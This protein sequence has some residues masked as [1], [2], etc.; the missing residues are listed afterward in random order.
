MIVQPFCSGRR[1][2]DKAFR[3]YRAWAGYF[4]TACDW[5][6]RQNG[7][8]KHPGVGS[9]FWFTAIFAT[10]D[11]AAPGRLPM[12]G[13]RNVRILIVDDNATNRKILHYQVS[14]WGMRDSVAS[15]GPAALALLRKGAALGDP[16]VV[17][18]L[19]AQMPELNGYQVVELIRADPIHCPRKGR[20]PYLSRTCGPARKFVQAGRCFYIKAS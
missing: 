11:T 2:D 9:K 15:S 12:G 19:D 7:S 3:R 20:P 14:A 16:Y 17:V 13:L 1:V 10:G 8:R 5:H 6:G 4:Q 18:I